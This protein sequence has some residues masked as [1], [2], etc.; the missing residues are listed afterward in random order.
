[1]AEFPNF[2]DCSSF[3]TWCLWNGLFLRYGLPDT[4]NGQ[5]WK[6]GFTGTL[7]DHGRRILEPGKAL[8]GDLVFYDDPTHVTIIVARVNGK[9]RVISHGSEVGP[10]NRE[11]DYRPVIQIRRYI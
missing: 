7:L 5:D 9:P 2:A 8:R 6:A 10:L 3:V 4:V 11:F 1:M